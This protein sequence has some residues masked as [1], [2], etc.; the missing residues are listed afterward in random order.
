VHDG[1]PYGPIEDL[2]F[3]ISVLVFASHDFELGRKLRC[4]LPKICH[5]IS[6][7]FGI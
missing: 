7:K 2:G 3:L 5:L 6:V 1:M 4:D